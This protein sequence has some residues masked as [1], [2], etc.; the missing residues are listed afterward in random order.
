MSENGDVD[1]LPPMARRASA[2]SRSGHA[3][4]RH[5]SNSPPMNPTLFVN[6]P[7]RLLADPAASVKDAEENHD[8]A[9]ANAVV[10]ENLAGPL[11]TLLPYRPGS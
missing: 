3:G 9:R 11:K 10:V 5:R 7:R 1:F 8:V 6:L 4:Q 2:I